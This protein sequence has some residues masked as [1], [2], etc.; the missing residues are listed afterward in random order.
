MMKLRKWLIALDFTPHDEKILQYSESLSQALMPDEIL[1]LHIMPDSNLP[2]NLFQSDADRK[3][4]LE[5]SEKSIIQDLEDMKAKYFGH[6][7]DIMVNTIILHGSPLPE[8]LRFTQDFQPDLL[9]VGKKVR[10]SGSGI[11]AQKLARRIQCAI[12]L[13]TE[14]ARYPAKKVLIPTDYSENA[15]RALQFA[16]QLRPLL[17]DPEIHCLYVYDVPLLLPYKIEMLPEQ[18]DE[19]YRKNAEEGMDKYLADQG[20]GQLPIVKVLLKNLHNSPARQIIDYAEEKTIN[21]II[22]GAKGRSRLESV[23]LGSTTEKM[24]QYNH[25]IPILIVR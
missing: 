25:E 18:M 14:S 12:L 23:I 2:E 20:I 24:L 21:L 19:L 1:M 8:L 4:Y 13:V 3:D 7:R 6:R 10:S 15:S 5:E 9:I 16:I 22:M 17:N 11:V